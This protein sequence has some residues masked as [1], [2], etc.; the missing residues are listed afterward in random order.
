MSIKTRI[1]AYDQLNTAN[2]TGLEL[3]S[4]ITSDDANAMP[5]N[6]ESLFTQINAMYKSIIELENRDS[7]YYQGLPARDYFSQLEQKIKDLKQKTKSLTAKSNDGDGRSVT[8]RSPSVRRAFQ[9]LY[10]RELSALSSSLEGDFDPDEVRISDLATPH[11][12]IRYMHQVATSLFFDPKGNTFNEISDRSGNYYF[13]QGGLSLVLVSGTPDVK[14]EKY[15][16]SNP[17]LRQF[18]E[19]AKATRFKGKLRDIDCF[20]GIIRDDKLTLLFQLGCHMATLEANRRQDETYA[21]HFKYTDSLNYSSSI[22]RARVVEAVLKTYDIPTLRKDRYVT[23]RVQGLPEQA[24]VELFEKLLR[25]N[26]S[27]KDI[28]T[29]PTRVTEGRLRDTVEAYHAGVLN[30]SAY[31]NSSK[32][33]TYY[34]WLEKA[35]PGYDRKRKEPKLEEKVDAILGGI[36][37]KIVEGEQQQRNKSKN[38]RLEW[39]WKDFLPEMRWRKLA[40]GTAFAAMVGFSAIGIYD[41]A[42]HIVDWCGSKASVKDEPYREPELYRTTDSQKVENE[43]TTRMTKKNDEEER[44]KRIGGEMKR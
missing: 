13:E 15:F 26:V 25:I 41:L 34:E 17:L 42:Y 37:E 27:I 43:T 40:T 22:F 35:Q 10:A 16:N 31:I 39:S 2:D 19:I 18:K 28:D 11:D 5:Q 1:E 33:G 8:T 23:S 44:T 9:Q 20:K 6:I 7:E 38:R 21:F 30:L 32:T 36:S 24:A 4:K 14:A 12:V 3:L 29:I